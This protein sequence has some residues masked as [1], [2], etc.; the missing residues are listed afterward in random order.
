LL[1][2]SPVS[3]FCSDFLEI[4]A[5]AELDEARIAG[6][7]GFPESGQSVIVED[8]AEVRLIRQ[9][10]ELAEELE[11]ETA[12]V[13]VLGDPGV[14]GNPV[15]SP[16][17]IPER[18]H[19]I[20]DDAIRVHVGRIDGVPGQLGPV[21]EEP[22]QLESQRQVDDPR[23]GQLVLRVRVCRAP[24]SVPGVGVVGVRHRLLGLDVG[25]G[26]GQG[27][28]SLEEPTVR[29]TLF[30]GEVDGLVIAL[31][32]VRDVPDV[33][34]GHVGP[35]VARPRDDAVL[36]LIPDQAITFGPDQVRGHREVL[37]KGPL[38]A[39][40]GLEAVGGDG[41]L[42]GF[43]FAQS[44]RTR[45]GGEEGV[46]LEGVRVVREDEG[47]DLDLVHEIGEEPAVQHGISRERPDPAAEGRFPV[48]GEVIAEAESGVEVPDVPVLDMQAFALEIVVPEPEV[49]GEP[50]DDLPVVLGEERGLGVRG[51]EKGRP[52]VV[53]EHQRIR[54]EVGGIKGR[55]R[56]EDEIA[57][58]VLIEF[59]RQGD[60]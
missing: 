18:V 13:D 52:A 2:I 20:L 48:A 55:V 34:L 12:D 43:V 31:S 3:D 29:I 41:V 8:V 60:V 47:L 56:R 37:E 30:D 53:Q 32:S 11:P 10:V 25:L 28:G 22:A 24:L 45:D 59:A 5:A 36:V 4:D 38:D 7:R 33:A 39:Q 42:F 44:H 50:G 57:G 35:L 40:R 17:R 14:Q 1:R 19:V 21:I 6:D 58:I 23:H 46:G 51:I 27:V 49:Q 15:E 16:A 26:R 54:G 9:V